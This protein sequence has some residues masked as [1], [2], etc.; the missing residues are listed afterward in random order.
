MKILKGAVPIIQEYLIFGGNKMNEDFD[1]KKSLRKAILRDIKAHLEPE[2]LGVEK[3][4]EIK[5]IEIIQVLERLCQ[6]YKSIL[7]TGHE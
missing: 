2:T 1:A 7:L 4:Q 6:S 5:P 3:G